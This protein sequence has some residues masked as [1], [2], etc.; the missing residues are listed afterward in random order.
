MKDLTQKEFEELRNFY[1]E[2]DVKDLT[3]KEWEAMRAEL[4]AIVPPL[5]M[6]SDSIVSL[7]KQFE[8]IADELKRIEPKK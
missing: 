2:G 1:R 8:R 7:A 5:T 6:I 3:R 4:A